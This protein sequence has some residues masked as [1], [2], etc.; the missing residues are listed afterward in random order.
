MK[1]RQDNIEIRPE[2]RKLKN[3]C[4]QRMKEIKNKHGRSNSRTQEKE[5]EKKEPNSEEKTK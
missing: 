4:G 3:E 5:N 1:N 2:K